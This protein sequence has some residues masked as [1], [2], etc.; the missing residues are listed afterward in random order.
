VSHPSWRWLLVLP[1]VGT[2]V[3]SLYNAWTPVLGG[4]PFFYWYLMAWIPLSALCTWTVHR[5]TRDTQEESAS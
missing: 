3:P 4:A 5:R 1:L 2:L